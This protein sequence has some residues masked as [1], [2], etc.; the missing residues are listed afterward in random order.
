MTCPSFT[1]ATIM[2]ANKLNEWINVCHGYWHTLCVLLKCVK[3]KSK[4]VTV[5][6]CL[7]N[8]HHTMKK[9]WREWSASCPGHF[10]PRNR[11][12]T[13]Q[14]IRGWMGPRIHLDAATCTKI[15]FLFLEVLPVRHS[16]Y[17]LGY[18]GSLFNKYKKKFH[19]RVMTHQV[20]NTGPH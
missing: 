7:S 15:F 6:W 20:C 4:V 12:L 9:D 11:T 13:I 14:W 2:D 19:S 3:C 5:A 1:V 10:S 8:K 17:W 16:L 18:S